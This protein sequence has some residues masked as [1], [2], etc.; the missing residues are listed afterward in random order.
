MRISD[1]SSDVCSSDL[2][3]LQR[4]TECGGKLA[5]VHRRPQRGKL[6]FQMFRVS[7]L[8]FQQGGEAAMRDQAA[9]LS[10]HREQHPHRTA[11]RRVGTECVSTCRYR[12]S[13]SHYKQSPKSHICTLPHTSRTA[14]SHTNTRHSPSS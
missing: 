9:V 13:P 7:A 14:Y 2:E 10:K 8:V 3:L 6:V 12:W 1:W 4:H 5:L 11:E